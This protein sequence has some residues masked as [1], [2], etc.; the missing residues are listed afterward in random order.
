MDRDSARDLLIMN[1]EGSGQ[2]GTRWFSGFSGTTSV[3]I[4]TKDKK[5]LL[6]DGRYLE[7][8]KKE[9]PGWEIIPVD[10]SG[11]LNAVKKLLKK[12]NVKKIT[13]DSARTSYDVIL[14]LSDFEI[15]PKPNVLQELRITKTQDQVAKIKAAAKIAM[16]AFAKLQIT[17]DMTERHAATELAY[18]MRKG[19]ADG[20][21]FDTIVVS[22]IRTALP[23]GKPTNKIIASGEL[24]TIDFGCFKD[25]YACDIT[26]TIA[27]GEVSPKLREIY[28]VVR[29]A[30]E[31]GCNAIKAG[32][33]GR[34]VDAVCRE[35]IAS[36]GYGEYFL[37]G[38]GH[39]LGMEVHELPYINHSNDKPLPAGAV[40][41]CEPG[42][43]I[44]GLGGAR[45]EDDLVVTQTG[46]ENLTID[47]K[48]LKVLPIR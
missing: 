29:E 47:S 34:E 20:M 7:Q 21:A 36:R 3:L 38:T 6:T 32:V 25:G 45:I 24:V 35:Y 10:R 12:L 41:T 13:L 23:H 17:A 19:G 48:E 28:K 46:S 33:T 9:S 31:R 8:V 26:R 43:Y 27:L 44:E 40:I 37:H 11:Y 1:I 4:Q 15:I 42:I 5:L 2:P 18:L 14:G 39:G 22:G 30:Q 16:D